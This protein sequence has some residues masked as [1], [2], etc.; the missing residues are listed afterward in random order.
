MIIPKANKKYDNFPCWIPT[1]QQINSEEWM[2]AKKEGRRKWKRYQV[3]RP[4][5]ICKCGAHL[6][7]QLHHIHR[8]GSVTASFYHQDGCGFHEHIT[9]ADWPGYDFPPHINTLTPP[10][11]T[12]GLQAWKKTPKS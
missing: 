4:V 8:D 12:R 2:A 6:G 1:V 10:V 5:I 7:C 11:M 9:L 3:H